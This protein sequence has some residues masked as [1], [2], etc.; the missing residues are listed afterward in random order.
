M[1]A[2]TPLLPLLRLLQL[3]PPVQ[4]MMMRGQIDMGHARALLPLA[5]ALQVQCLLTLIGHVREQAIDA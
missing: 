1:H 5:G 3:V 4:E 2:A